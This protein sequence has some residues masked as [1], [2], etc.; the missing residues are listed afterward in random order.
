VRLRF[1]SGDRSG[2][3]LEVDAESLTIGRESDADLVLD[4]PDVSRRHA[5]IYRGPDGGWLAEDLGST[6]GTRIDG[7]R[8]DAPR[9]LA[10]GQKLKMGN[11]VLTVLEVDP[12]ATRVRDRSDTPG[13]DRTS[14]RDVP[15]PAAA[16]PPPR[17]PPPPQQ[18]PA[19]RQPAQPDRSASRIQSAIERVRLQRSAKRATILAGAA[20]GIAL[21]VIVLAVAGVFSGDSTPSVESVVSNVTPSTVLVVTNKDGKRLGSGT[22]WVYDA[23]KGLIVTNGHVINGGDHFRIGVGDKSRTAK[24]V[25]VAPCED[26]AL[27]KVSD[28]KDLKTL[29]L[30]SQ[31]DLKEGQSVVALGFP[32]NASL[33][34]NLTS[35]SGVVSVAKTRLRAAPAEEA[36]LPNIV[37]TDAAINPGNSGGPLVNLNGKLVG[38]NTATATELQSQGYAIGVDRIK[39]ILATLT[40]GKSIGWTGLGFDFPEESSLQSQ[41]LPK[42]L[43]ISNVVPGTPAVKANLGKDRLLVTNV[44]G[45]NLDTTLQS[46]CKAVKDVSSGESAVFEIRD[47]SNA[48][49]KVRVKFA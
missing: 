2:E 47:A 46:Y 4:D 29:P 5:R 3:T 28:H 37:Q 13:M 18:P 21:L 9:S 1:D 22:G 44:A 45:E 16:A 19:P 15:V 6:N 39:T 24:V 40:G 26:M 8:L 10:P 7:L 31:G 49:Q 36:E 17:Q 34:D 23:G 12:G 14:V 48:V 11:T 38:M 32:T 27:L 35:T 42:G 41:G 33:D 20:L 30:G 43:I 25:A